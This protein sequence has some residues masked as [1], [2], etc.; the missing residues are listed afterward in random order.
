MKDEEFLSSFVQV[1]ELKKDRSPSEKK[2]I[3]DMKVLHNVL[4]L[5]RGSNIVHKDV[6]ENKDYS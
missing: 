6:I 5:E 3:F 1:L 4:Q 2:L